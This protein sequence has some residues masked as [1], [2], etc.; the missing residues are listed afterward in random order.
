LRSH[1]HR[2]SALFDRARFIDQHHSIRFPQALPDQ[3]LMDRDDWFR[4][5]LALPNIVLQTSHFLFLSKRHLFH[6]LAGNITQQALQIDQA[7]LDLLHSLKGRFEMSLLYF[8]NYQ[9][10]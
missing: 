9:T 8:F 1:P 2:F 10:V 3:S 5:P 6:I 7:F 4:F